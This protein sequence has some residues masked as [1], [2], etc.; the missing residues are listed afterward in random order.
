MPLS[1]RLSETYS[2]IWDNLKSRRLKK[3]VNK[4]EGKAK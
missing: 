4:N 2:R 3:K 1:W